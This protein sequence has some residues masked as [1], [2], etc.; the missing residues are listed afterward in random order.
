VAT[1]PDAD[2]IGGLIEV[3]DAFI[4]EEIWLNGDTRTSQTYTDFRDKVNAEEAWGAQV[5]RQAQRG[6]T[7]SVSG[8]SFEVLH[9]TLPLGSDKNENSIV[10]K[11][12]FGQVDFL[13]TGDAEN[14]AESSMLAAGVLNNVDILKVAHHGSDTS[15]GQAF[16]SVVQPEDSI[17]MVGSNSYGHP[18]A[19][20]ISR[21]EVYGTVWRTDVYGDIVVMTDGEEYSVTVAP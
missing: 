4:V 17:I 16:L 21:L 3:L 5:H 1:H 10:L 8:L 14:D 12:S 18:D 19:G 2:H 15:S 20:T 13:F 11:L 9:P 7:I 6:N